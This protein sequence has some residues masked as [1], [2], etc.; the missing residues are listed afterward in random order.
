MYIFI[1]Q[2]IFNTV[3]KISYKHI[4]PIHCIKWVTEHLPPLFNNT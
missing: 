3:T 1:L 2:N 4:Q